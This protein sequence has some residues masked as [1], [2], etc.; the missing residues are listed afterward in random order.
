MRHNAIVNTQ[1]W[2][3]K[4]QGWTV[5]TERP[6]SLPNGQALKPDIV[7]AREG[8]AVIIDAQV[9]S[10]TAD[11]RMPYKA[12]RA[13]YNRNYLRTAIRQRRSVKE[14]RALGIPYGVLSRITTRTLMG[15][16]FNWWSFGK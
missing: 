15:S 14:L 9:V 8:K 13:K 7:A 10:W 16:Y 3:L 11:L 2:T 5:E 1:E 12:K 4:V 6:Y